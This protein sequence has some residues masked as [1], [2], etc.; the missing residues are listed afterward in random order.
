MSS[1][2][3]KAPFCPETILNTLFGLV[4]ASIPDSGDC[5]NWSPHLWWGSMHPDH[6]PPTSP[7]TLPHSPLGPG[8]QGLPQKQL[9]WSPFLSPTTQKLVHAACPKPSDPVS[10]S[11][12]HNRPNEAILS[13]PAMAL[14]RCI[15]NTEVGLWQRLAHT[16]HRASKPLTSPM[17]PV[18]TPHTGLWLCDV[19]TR[20]AVGGC[21]G[22]TPWLPP[23]RV[24]PACMAGPRT[25]DMGSSPKPN[26]QQ[27]CSV[28]SPK[29]TAWSVSLSTKTIEMDLV[30]NP[31]NV[32][33]GFHSQYHAASH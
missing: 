26:L 12:P 16:H 7:P 13:P 25:A 15:G 33:F 31:Q 10:I 30:L 22:P 24:C 17:S 9:T 18:P 27:L 5:H 21:R 14:G 11:E 19:G 1:G 3:G 8:V 2:R 20:G 29:H 28:P 32:G 6:P 4:R 23:A